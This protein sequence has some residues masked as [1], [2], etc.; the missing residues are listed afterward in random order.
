MAKK[1]KPKNKVTSKK[2]SKYKIE[3]DKIERKA[4]CPKCGAGTFLAVHKGRKHCGK[5]AYTIFE[6]KETSNSVTIPE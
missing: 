6:G 5:C 3:G 2:F 1:P 4:T